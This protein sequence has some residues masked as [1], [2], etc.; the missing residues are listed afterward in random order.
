MACDILNRILQ[1][2]LLAVV[3]GIYLSIIQQQHKIYNKTINAVTKFAHFAI[4]FRLMFFFN[5]FLLTQ[6]SQTFNAKKL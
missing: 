6:F 4:N 5:F 3:L 1:Y 2:H